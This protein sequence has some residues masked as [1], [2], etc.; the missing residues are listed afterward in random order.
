MKE[1][2]KERVSGVKCSSKFKDGK[3]RKRSLD[4]ALVVSVEAASA[5]GVCMCVCVG[6]GQ[7]AETKSEDWVI[8]GN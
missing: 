1:G 3:T 5:R 4:R 7:G 2:F 8:N 6:W